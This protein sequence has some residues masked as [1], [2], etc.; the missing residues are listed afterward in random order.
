MP[1]AEREATR[2]FAFNQGFYNL[3]LAIALC[4]A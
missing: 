3:F 1:D 4:S 2:A